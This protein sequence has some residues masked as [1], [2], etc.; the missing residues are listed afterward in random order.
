LDIS[1]FGPLSVKECERHFSV[2]S[3]RFWTL[4]GVWLSNGLERA[5][6]VLPLSRL[7]RLYLS[8]ASTITAGVARAIVEQC[9]DTL[10]ALCLIDCKLRDEPAGALVSSLS[11]LSD[12]TLPHNPDLSDRTL[13]LLAANFSLTTRLTRLDLCGCALISEKAVCRLVRASPRLQC[14]LIE[15]CL[16]L[17]D[18]T[19]SCIGETCGGLTE[20]DVSGL[21]MLSPDPV[22]RLRLPRLRSLRLADCAKLT[23][24][25][26]AGCV[27][28]CEALQ[29][30][31]ISRAS[32][33]KLGFT[34][35]IA[36][37]SASLCRLRK[38][39][40][41]GCAVT[42]EN[43]TMLSKHCSALTSLNLSACAKIGDGAICDVR[44]R[45][46]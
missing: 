20:L 30:L 19:V 37:A 16:K 34:D 1:S 26:V 36:A 40:V 29:Q 43:V 46:P 18:E 22:A 23:A 17:G 4:T 6:D 5:I 2:T 12:L 21:P 25:G 27:L 31:C 15:G 42:D 39:H 8:G 7:R 13:N 11:K 14:L 44:T 33:Q 32:L 28:S 9:A 41:D 10:D 3:S 24:A 45:V 38:L 35:V